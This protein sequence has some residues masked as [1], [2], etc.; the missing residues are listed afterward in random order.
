MS[1]LDETTTMIIGV[2]LRLVPTWEKP[3][4]RHLAFAIN[5]TA[6]D[7]L[8]WGVYRRVYSGGWGTSI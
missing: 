6:S 2:E 1:D 7:E 3:A 5:T 8:V 4:E